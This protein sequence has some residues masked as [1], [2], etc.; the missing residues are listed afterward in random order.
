MYE[1]A[2]RNSLLGSYQ[3]AM[4]HEVIAWIRLSRAEPVVS[5]DR[6]EYLAEA[7]TRAA[8]A[9]LNMGAIEAFI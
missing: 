8:E 2:T 3:Q 5:A 6:E 7:R 9:G 1:V 4:T